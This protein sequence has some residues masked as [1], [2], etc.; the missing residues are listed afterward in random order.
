MLSP[1]APCVVCGLFWDSSSLTFWRLGFS[2]S[3]MHGYLWY[4]CPPE[5]LPHL[6]LLS[7][8]QR[9]FLFVF[10]E[11]SSSLSI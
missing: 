6:Y 11:I 8:G 4:Q 5:M 9:Y 7:R 1:Y 2:A 10:M 3:S